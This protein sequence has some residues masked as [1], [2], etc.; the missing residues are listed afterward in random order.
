V[1]PLTVLLLRLL[2]GRVGSTL[3]MQLLASSEAV[4]CARIPPYERRC[5]AYLVGRAQ[6]EALARCWMS[7]SEAA[8]HE[9][10]SPP[11]YYAEKMVGDLDP[12]IDAGIPFRVIDVVRDPRDI[13]VSARAF[14]GR[15][16]RDHFGLRIADPDRVTLP[17]FLCDMAVRLEAI[18]TCRGGVEPVLVRYEDMVEDLHGVAA[19]LSRTL[20]LELDAHR[21]LAQADAHR[22]HMT[23]RSVSASIGRWRTELPPPAARLLTHML[24]EPLRRFG[25]VR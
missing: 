18:G 11:R 13:Y 17:V 2:H 4:V 20:G 14:A 6:G 3:L 25:Y 22:A 16:G 12:L 7:F 24:A 10:P 23:A 21:V 19:T 8:R 9:R 1:P 5:L 15:L